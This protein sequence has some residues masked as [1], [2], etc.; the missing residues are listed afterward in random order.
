MKGK[1]AIRQGFEW[2]LGNMEQAGFK[3]LRLWTD[4]DSGA[5]EMDTHHVFKGSMEMKFTQVFVI[6]RVAPEDKPEFV[7][8]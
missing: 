1:D 3:V 4:G 8:R 7:L 6:D 2:A 5:V